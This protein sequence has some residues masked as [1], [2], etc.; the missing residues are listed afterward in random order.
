MVQPRP[1]LWATRVRPG[2]AY[3]SLVGLI[4]SVTRWFDDADEARDREV[5]F[6]LP[7]FISF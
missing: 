7:L 2:F 5:Y 4:V 3:G 6:T 1:G